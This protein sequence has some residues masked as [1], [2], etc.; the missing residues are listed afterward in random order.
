MRYM[1]TK[2]LFVL[3]VFLEDFTENAWMYI[4]CM[5]Y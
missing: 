3:Q 1:N 2:R 5:L 4:S